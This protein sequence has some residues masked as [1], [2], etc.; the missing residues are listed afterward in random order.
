MARRWL[1]PGGRRRPRPAR[2]RGDRA[3][4][5]RSLARR[6]QR[7]RAARRAGLA[8][9][10]H[11]RTRRAPA[12]GWGG[13]LAELARRSKRVDAACATPRA[14]TL[15]IAAERL[16]Q[17]QAL[18]PDAR[19]RAADRRAGADAP[20]APGRA[21]RR[22]SRSCAAGS[23][24]SARSTRRRSPRRSA[25]RRDD[26][27]ARARR[28]ARPKASRCAAAS[29]P[30]PTRDEW[31]ER[32]L[33]ARIHR[34]T[35]KRLRAEI[36]PVA[37]RDFLRFLFDWQ[38]V[39]PTRR[40]WRGRTRSPRCSASSKASRRR[41]AP[42]R[43]RSCRRAS[44]ATSR[45]GSTTSA[46]PGASPG[47]GCGRATAAA[48][49][50]TR[51]RRAGADDADHPARRAGTRRCGPRCRRA[52]EPA[53]AERPRAQAVARLHRA[54]H[55]ASFF[56]ELVDGT[57]LLRTAGRG[58][59]RP[60]WS[61][62][63]LVNSDSFAGLRALLVPAEQRKP[64]GGGSAGAARARS[65]WRTPAA[66]RWRAAPPPRR[67]TRR[68][69]RRRGRAPR[70]HAAAPLRR[71]V[72]APARARGRW[73]PPWRDLLRVYRRLEARGE[74]RGGRFVAGFSGEQFALPEAVGAAARDRAA[75]R[76]PARSCRCRGADPL[77]LVGILTPGPKLAALTGN[78]V[79]YR[80]GMPVALLAGGEVQFLA[81]ARSGR[82]MGGAQG[83][84]AR[85]RAG[86]AGGAG[87]EQKH[88]TSPLPPNNT[89]LRRRAP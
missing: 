50:A 1:A 6:R 24:G 2:P 87:D 70:A 43:P 21:R 20:S 38:R 29:R 58:G 55:G 30:A 3:G 56:D 61:R 60:S 36:E 54:T 14:A 31:C 26:I 68:R 12:P 88:P 79:L 65:A 5:R 44:P 13:W 77:N 37:A 49:P 39:T 22:W 9:L 73:L 23:K 52:G 62:S 33:L 66:G 82:R 74:I 71:R 17:F 51:Q 41:P 75:S 18:W 19:A 45:P 86:A 83:A 46:S 69:R 48:E 15:W 32:R 63:G 85:R 8:R 81:G 47:R 40:A 59:A 57:G 78:R 34:Y 7:R 10:P 35:V 67:R 27:A 76:R 53:Q 89:T 64:L 80:D 84:A 16:P 25:S 11:A 4:A 28:A 42:G 72:L